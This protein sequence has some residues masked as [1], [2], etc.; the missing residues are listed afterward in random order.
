MSIPLT[1]LT[2]QYRAIQS[3]VDEAISR[4]LQ[5]GSF[6]LGSEVDAFER[7]MSSF[8][9]TSHAVGVASGTDALHLALLACGIGEGDEV[10]TTPFTFIAT[11]E[12]IHKC[13]ATPVFVD[14]EP[15]TCNMDLRLLE[16]KLTGAT[17]AIV[18][19]HLYGQPCDMTQLS[20]FAAANSLK[21]VE[22]CAQSLG[23]TWRGRQTGSF[24]DAG[25]LSFF[26]SK[27]LGAYGDGG[28]V[29]TSNPAVAEHVRVLRSHG[30]KTK[31]FHDMPGFNS[32]LDSLQAAVLRVK[33]RHLP[34]WLERRREIAALYAEHLG[35][36]A[37]IRLLAEREG[38][39]HVYNYYAIRVDGGSEARDALAAHLKTRGVATAVYYPKSLHLQPV[40]AELGHKPGDFSVSELAQQEMLA[41][42]MYPELTDQQVEEIADAIAS[43]FSER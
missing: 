3:D 39:R 12:S 9:G 43:F 6:I 2:A 1:D 37:G 11:A 22:D 14:I 40:Y 29:V 31:Y 4:T 8:C 28:M 23:A 35:G 20:S 5:S 25:C 13:G 10:L 21:I 32:R 27:V 30:S 15:D 24:G 34:S 19:V 26:P 17:R 18:P 7:E 41:L 33:L 38:A 16:R 42:P 36:I